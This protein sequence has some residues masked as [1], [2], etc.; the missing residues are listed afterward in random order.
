MTTQNS[1][2]QAL[3]AEPENQSRRL[4]YADWL[5]EHGSEQANLIRTQVQL[6]TT[7][8][9]SREFERLSARIDELEDRL[10]PD[11]ISS[12]ARIGGSRIVVAGGFVHEATFPAAKFVEH[13]AQVLETA[14]M[15]LSISLH[16]TRRHIDAIV[17]QGLLNDFTGLRLA[18]ELLRPDQ[19]AQLTGACHRLETLD[20]RG[21]MLGA[22][23]LEMLLTSNATK[24]LKWLDLSACW[25]DDQCIDW[26]IGGSNRIAQL[27][28]LGLRNNR[29][30][31]EGVAR[32]QNSETLL[33]IPRFEL[34]RPTMPPSYDLRHFDFDDLDDTFY[35]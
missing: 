1:L 30:S 9:D 6:E 18:S 16:G 14:P 33:R 34:N 32:L 35:V 28:Y 4:I 11:W 2:L 7:A 27:E 8:R 3:R 20:L 25:L 17:A 26:L 12:L 5:E 29:F 10:T 15:L 23:G 31:E 19:L 21:N 13:A 22:A 24:R